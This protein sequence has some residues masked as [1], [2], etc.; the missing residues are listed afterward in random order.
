M[1][2]SV[3]NKPISRCALLLGLLCTLLSGCSRVDHKQSALDPKGLVA[4]NQYDIFM[5]SVWITIFLFCAVGGCLLYVLWK[6]RVKNEEE[7]KEV[8]PQSHGNSKIEFGLIVAS[9][10]IFEESI[11]ERVTRVWS[12]RRSIMYSKLSSNSQSNAA[13]H[14]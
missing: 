6:Y 1:I 14:L 2:S 12:S 7:A 8:P 13:D 11:Q 9:S 4:Q 3:L 5:L 10:I